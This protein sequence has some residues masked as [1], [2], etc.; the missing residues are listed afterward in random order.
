MTDDSAVPA[1]QAI[2]GWLSLEPPDFLRR[3]VQ[4]PFQ[5]P[6]PGGQKR[7]RVYSGVRLSHAESGLA[8]EA[9]ESREA[10]RNLEDALHR[11]RLA[12]ALSLPLSAP[13]DPSPPDAP[14]TPGCARTHIPAPAPPSPDPRPDPGRPAVVRP[15]IRVDAN[16]R[17]A[18]FPRF[19]LEALAALDAAEG[20]LSRAGSNL[21]VTS[22]ALT[23]FLRSEKAVWAK[24]QEIR[25]RHGLHPLKNG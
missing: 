17:H 21:G 2:R 1:L 5:G 9:S 3:C 10:R 18:D 13:R 19:V 7:N 12:M 20:G 23:R 8:A 25:K 22:S 15:R 4:T 11:L 14:A 24:A 16:P 6:G